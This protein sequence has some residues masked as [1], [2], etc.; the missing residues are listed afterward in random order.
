M[1]VGPEVAL[2]LSSEEAGAEAGDAT[3]AA[4]DASAAAA[5]GP[6]EQIVV[7]GQASVDAEDP[8]AALDAFTDTVDQVGGRISTSSR[9]ADDQWPTAS[10]TARVPA[11]R[12]QE[13]A[14]TLAD[15]GKVVD[16]TTTTEDV[17]QQMAD[18]DARADALQTSVDRLSE[19]IEQASSTKDLLEAERELTNRQAELDSLNGQRDWLTDQVAFSTLSVTFA[20]DVQPVDPNPSVWER[21]WQAFLRSLEGLFTAVVVALPWAA[22][23]ALVAVPAVVVVRRRRARRRSA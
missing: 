18:L 15:L 10:A 20:T 11:D 19:L 5:D 7:T 12:Y 14:D 1:P 13:L 16:V 8:A 22:A 3:G 6:Q 17:G 2:D 4:A 21:S 9:S 23:V